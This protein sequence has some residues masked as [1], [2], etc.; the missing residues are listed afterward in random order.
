M[1]AC[2]D[3]QL[4][5]ARA[6]VLVQQAC[7]SCSMHHRLWRMYNIHHMACFVL[8]KC[9]CCITILACFAC[10]P[11]PIHPYTQQLPPSQHPAPNM[12]QP[13]VRFKVCRLNMQ[14]LRHTCNSSGHHIRCFFAH[15][16]AVATERVFEMQSMADCCNMTWP[17][18]SMGSAV[19]TWR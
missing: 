4:F 5:N 15:T 19:S 7:S 6:V 1:P 18:Q 9:F 14:H 17:M 3:P 13:H 12:W 16:L 11:H 10:T 2:H 8:M